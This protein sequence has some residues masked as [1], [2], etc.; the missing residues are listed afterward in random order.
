[1]TQFCD[2]LPDPV[3]DQAMGIMNHN[4]SQP[5]PLASFHHRAIE[6]V[7]DRLRFLRLLLFQ[8]PGRK[9]IDPELLLFSEEFDRLRPGIKAFVEAAFRENKFQETPILRGI[10]FSS[11]RQEGSPYSHFLKALGLIQE[12]EVLPGT[13]RG[14]SSMIFSRGSCQKTDLFLP[15]PRDGWSGDDSRETLGSL[16]GSW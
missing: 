16:L 11:G 7:V 10:Y 8:K 9:G 12:K 14:F 2:R 3:L 15:L 1:M 6:K 13:S 5:E 4:V